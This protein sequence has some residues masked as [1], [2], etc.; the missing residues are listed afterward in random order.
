MG[1]LKH[2]KEQLEQQ[3]IAKDQHIK[4]DRNKLY[5]Y[6]LMKGLKR[7]EENLEMMRSHVNYQNKMSRF[8]RVFCLLL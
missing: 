8:I 6:V 5:V 1:S 7:I 2:A 3:L 4:V